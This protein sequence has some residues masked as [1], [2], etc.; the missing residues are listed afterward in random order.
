M[1]WEY[2]GLPLAVRLDRY[3]ENTYTHFLSMWIH[4]ERVYPFRSAPLDSPRYPGFA[5]KSFL[6]SYQ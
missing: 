3:V 1:G 4:L 5:T 2:V 6:T